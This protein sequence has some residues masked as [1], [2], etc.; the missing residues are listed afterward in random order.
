[1]R[2]SPRLGGMLELFERLALAGGD[3]LSIE[4]TG[5]KELH[6]DALLYCDV[7]GVV[8]AL[9]VLG[10]RDMGF[11]WKKIVDVARKAGVR[12]GGDT[13]SGFANTAIVLAEKK[14]I[15]PP[16]VCRRPN[17]VRGYGHGQ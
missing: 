7:K 11:L 15:E 14:Y 2:S 3:F 5:G 16:R 6:D 1:M 9:A 8:F 10:V 4:S 12:A 13:A 17:T